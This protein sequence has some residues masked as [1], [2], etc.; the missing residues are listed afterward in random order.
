MQ[1]SRILVTLLGKRTDLEAFLSS[2]AGRRVTSA[3]IAGSVKTNP[4]YIRQRMAAPRSAGITKSWM[5]RDGSKGGESPN[6]ERNQ[7]G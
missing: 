7:N 4:A 5:C 3:R 1:A 6:K 2:G